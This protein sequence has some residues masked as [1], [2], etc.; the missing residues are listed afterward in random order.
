M[1][2][3]GLLTGQLLI[4]LLLI[5]GLVDFAY[6]L[7]HFAIERGR[8]LVAHES[9]AAADIWNGPTQR[10]VAGIGNVLVPMTSPVL[11]VDATGRRSTGQTTGP[12]PTGLLL[13]SSQA[14]G[15]RVPD[16]DT[17]A[18]ALERR[19]GGVTV[20]NFSAPG[21][22]VSASMTQWLKLAESGNAPDFVLVLFSGVQIA[23]A[24]WK[25]DPT[26]RSEREPALVRAAG[27]AWTLLFPDRSGNYPCASAEAREWVVLR[28]LYEIRAAVAAAR[29]LHT[30]FALVVAPTLYGNDA[31]AGTARSQIDPEIVRTMN[32]TVRE[33]R[34]R[35]ASERIPGVVDLSA[36]FDTQAD[37][38]FVDRGSHF[39]RQGAE[40]LAQA[41][42]ER[43]P[44]DFFSKAGG[45]S[46]P[47]ANDVTR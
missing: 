7:A 11:N 33:L 40:I 42:V 22:T 17:F 10:A 36:A 9:P 47:P 20:M 30:R 27:K 44:A 28:T 23:E 15:F 32:L 45:Q 18:A 21:R 1:R 2:K 39:D 34:E 37:S 24:C 12:G 43:L 35:L 19:L 14:F 6:P 41:V 13:G 29:D 16:D 25:V 5:D 8:A 38:R 3:F 46:A 4:V 26:S 31:P